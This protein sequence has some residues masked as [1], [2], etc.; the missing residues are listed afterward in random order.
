MVPFYHNR[1]DRELKDLLSY[2]NQL[3]NV[4]DVRLVN[5]KTFKLKKLLTKDSMK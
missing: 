3:K 2:L 5:Q 1:V 4:E